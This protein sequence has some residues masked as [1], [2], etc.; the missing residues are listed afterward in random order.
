MGIA[1]DVHYRLFIL[2][3]FLVIPFTAESRGSRTKN[4]RSGSQVLCMFLSVCVCVCVSVWCVCV[5]VCVS[6]C[7]RV[8]KHYNSKTLGPNKTVYETVS[9]EF[10]FENT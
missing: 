7:L 1:H 10:N 9:D 6:V 5:C 8:C 3:L 4:L 2:G